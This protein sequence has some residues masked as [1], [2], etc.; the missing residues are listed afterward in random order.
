M[1][2]NQT[3]KEKALM[4]MIEDLKARLREKDEHIADLKRQMR[5][6]VFMGKDEIMT[7]YGMTEYMAKKWV[8]LGMPVLILDG[9]WYA[10]RDNINAFFKAKTMVNSSNAK[11]D[12]E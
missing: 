9:T 2:D 12:G 8:K 6:G 5:D 3:E 11:L 1:A 10:N 7:A 4:R